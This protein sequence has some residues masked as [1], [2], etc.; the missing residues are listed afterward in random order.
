VHNLLFIQSSN[1]F[2]LITYMNGPHMGRNQ[3]LGA[4]RDS[5]MLRAFEDSCLRMNIPLGDYQKLGDKIFVQRPP[6]FL[7]LVRHPAAGAEAEFECIES[8]CRTSVEWSNG[9]LKEN[10][11]FLQ[12]KNRLSIQMSAVGQYCMVAGILTNALTLCNGSQTLS[13]F[14]NSEQ[15]PF[16]LEMPTLEY[17]FGM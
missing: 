16:S 9:K 8:K 3:D 12:F 11:K 7:A 14:N 10:W 4:F 15:D 6:S 2:G 17:Y 1:A 5:N 13:Y